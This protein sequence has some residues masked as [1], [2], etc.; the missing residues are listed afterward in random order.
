MRRKMNEY[1]YD[2]QI[3]GVESA[4]YRVHDMVEA[5]N[6]QLSS[7]LLALKDTNE[8]LDKIIE[9]IRHEKR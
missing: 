2:N 7:I 6:N 4:V 9:I 1:C 8:K 5:N 3:G